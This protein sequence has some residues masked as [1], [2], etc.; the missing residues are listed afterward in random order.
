MNNLET[1]CNLI[2]HYNNHTEYKKMSF[3]MI[4]ITKMIQCTHFK[5][6]KDQKL[7][8]RISVFSKR[9]FNAN[10]IFKE[11]DHLH[12]HK[13][14]NGSKI[15]S[16]GLTV[17]ILNSDELFQY[18]TV[19]HQSYTTLF[20]IMKKIPDCIYSVYLPLSTKLVDIPSSQELI[21]AFNATHPIKYDG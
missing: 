7:L 10:M 12:L 11:E 20:E 17:D 18:S 16:H 15:Q 21:D 3:D 6:I 14:C 4:D 2:K 13:H 8:F 9:Y 5:I 1:I 19:L